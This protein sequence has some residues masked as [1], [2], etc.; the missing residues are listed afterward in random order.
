MGS[1]TQVKKNRKR[2][3]KPDKLLRKK[4][5]LVK[6]FDCLSILDLDLA[7]TACAEYVAYACD[8]NEERQLNDLAE[9]LGTASQL[10]LD[11]EQL[12]EPRRRP[13]R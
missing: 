11:I 10:K 4:A 12:S 2:E 7:S 3:T 6:I 9:A 13:V 5:E 8:A 1:T